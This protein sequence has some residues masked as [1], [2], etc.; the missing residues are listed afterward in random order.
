M[1]ATLVWFSGCETGGVNEFSATSTGGGPGVSADSGTK[2]TGSYGLKVGH[3]GYAR[4]K[5][6]FSS[7]ATTVLRCY[8][9]VTSNPTNTVPVLLVANSTSA[10]ARGFRLYL[11]TA[12]K[13]GWGFNTTFGDSP[14]GTGADSVSLTDWNLLEVKMVRDATVG[15]MEIFLNGVQ[16][17]SDFTHSTTSGI[18]ATTLTAFFGNDLDQ[19]GTNQSGIDIWWDD[20]AFGTGSTYIGAGGSVAVQ[21]KAGAPTYDAWTKVGDITAAA[22]W[23]ETPF[24]TAKACTDILTGDKQTMLVDDS[25]L[26]G[27]VGAT[28]VINGAMV[29]FVAKSASG[30]PTI[31]V[32]RRTSGSDVLS[33]AFSLGTVD[34]MIPD[35]VNGDSLGIFVD[36]RANLGGSEIGAESESSTILETVE[37]VWLLVDVSPNPNI[38]ITPSAG[39][40]VITGQQADR[41]DSDSPTFRPGSGSLSL[42]GQPVS[43]QPFA[44]G[45]GAMALTGH[46]ARVSVLQGLLVK[47]DIW[48]PVTTPLVVLFDVQAGLGSSPTP[49][50]VS[51]D[52]IEQNVTPFLITFDIVPAALVDRLSS[53][54]VVAGKKRS[55][56]V[57]GP[58]AKVR[59]T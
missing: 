7:N 21:G 42:T 25:A 23:S 56:D 27:L 39:G 40:L 52:I 44:A 16:Q 19:P 48:D 31:K 4:A 51:F 33:S 54:T 5:T 10:S 12:G 32:L 26:N 8:F 17:V 34:R 11:T 58:V 37:D 9:R 38:S 20:M 15:G 24:S 57:Q 28:D 49:F 53:A 22:C 29:R 46:V 6:N 45:A 1:A 35:P 59:F 47:F 43:K 14:D 50:L 2:R 36:T 13:I 55:G 3:D 18:S 30:A 41:T